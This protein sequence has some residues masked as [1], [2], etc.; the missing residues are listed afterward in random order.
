MPCR[1]L[2]PA[3]P[4]GEIL[5]EALKARHHEPFER[6]LGRAVRQLGG[7][8]DEYLTIVAEVREYGRTH[9][10]EIRD[11]ARALANQP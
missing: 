11:A 10:L 7:G 8:F 9:K 1:S 5:K 6:A 2:P 3:I 4:H